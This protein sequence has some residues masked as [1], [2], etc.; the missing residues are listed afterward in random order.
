MRADCSKQCSDSDVFFGS[1]DY[2]YVGGYY[3]ASEE[4]AMMEEVAHN[5]PFVVALQVR[6]IVSCMSHL[7]L[8]S[9]LI[10]RC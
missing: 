10:V 5:G 1:S 4:V 9:F 7:T 2:G 3:G 8:M 6:F